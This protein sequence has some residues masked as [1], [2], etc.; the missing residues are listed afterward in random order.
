MTNTHNW[1][2]AAAAIFLLSEAWVPS[3]SAA[4]GACH[5]PGVHLQVLGSGGP[6][7]GDQRASSG[8]LVWQDGRARVLVDM[9]AGSLLNF[10]RA[11][12]RIE[13]LDAILLSHLHVD[14]AAD[15]PALVKASYFSG[16]RRD[17]PV[18][19]PTGNRLMPATSAFLDALFK[20]GEGAY[21]YLGSYLTGE[22]DYRLYAVEVSADNKGER[23]I[24][25]RAGVVSH[26]S[27]RSRSR[28]I[29]Y[30]TRQF[31]PDYSASIS[32]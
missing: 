9:G 6:E 17:L 26:A 1:I 15:L 32:S 20:D 3:A 10:E 19:G 4:D 14:H 29:S 12:G 8:Y 7:L 28:V 24:F 16:R 13:D 21:R 11:G 30:R 5:G 22:D 18:Y 31:V 23:P 27:P 25:E 2:A